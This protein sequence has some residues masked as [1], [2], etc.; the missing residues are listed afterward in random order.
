M[1]RV[2]YLKGTYNFSNKYT[3]KLAVNEI[4]QNDSIVLG[5]RYSGVS[6]W[7]F[8]S[9][10]FCTKNKPYLTI[11]PVALTFMT[12][13]TIQIMTNKNIGDGNLL[14]VHSLEILIKCKLWLEII[15]Q[16]MIDFLCQ[17]IKIM[18]TY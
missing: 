14:I 4:V 16:S 13:D 10:F 3:R 2:L 18:W 9:L 7:L 5:I 11:H 15:S 17:C 6:V 12:I 1:I 8:L